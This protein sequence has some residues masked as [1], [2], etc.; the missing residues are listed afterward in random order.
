MGR[1][2][3]QA[4][5]RTAGW[6]PS[7]VWAHGGLLTQPQLTHAHYHGWAAAAAPGPVGT[8]EGY[9]PPPS[10]GLRRRLHHGGTAGSKCAQS[11][12]VSNL[13]VEICTKSAEGGEFGG[14]G[15]G[16]AP[17]KC[18]R[19]G[20]D[21]AVSED[22]LGVWGLAPLGTF[23]GRRCRGKGSSSSSTLRR[24]RWPEGIYKIRALRTM[25]RQHTP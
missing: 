12:L 21:L 7:Y 16:R 19:F 5:T 23:Y 24:R 14:G 18:R 1:A 11:V 9:R 4:Q 15:W 2:R 20:A 25:P 3:F 22:V 6:P 8:R 10:P 13:R 17:T